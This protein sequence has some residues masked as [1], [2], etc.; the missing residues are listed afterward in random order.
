MKYPYLFLCA[1][2]GLLALISCESASQNADL[3]STKLRITCTTNI[4]ADLVKTIAGDSAEVVS[5]MGAGID[6]HL[7]KASAGDLDKLADADVIFYNGLAL[8]GKMGDIL[9]KMAT[10]KP[11]FA[12]SDIIPKDSLRIIGKDYYDPHIWFD[13][14]LWQL[15]A[16]H[17]SQELQALA[18]SAATYFKQRERAYLKDLQAL[19]SYIHEAVGEIPTSRRL[20]I[21]SHDAF[22]YFG[23]RYGVEVRGLLGISTVTESSLRDVNEL[24]AFIIERK[25]PAI[26]IETSVSKRDLQAVLEGCQAKGHNLRIGGELYAD[27]L[28]D[29]KAS[30]Y[31]GMMQENVRIFTEAMK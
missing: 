25:V 9:E 7:Y 6:P 12:V 15:A 24:V 8:E 23:A 2:L 18:P 31:I 26:F 17:V 28:G 4:V 19:E 10:K 5:L 1:M 11:V 16:Q 29:G 14:K 3:Q 20:L 30:N 21:T 13:A 22:F 27:A